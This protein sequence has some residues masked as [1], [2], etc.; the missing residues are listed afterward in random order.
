MKVRK[1]VV[2]AAGLG[3]RFLPLTKAAPKE[4]LPLLN[5]PV[6]Q[7]VL[8][9]AVQSG[10]QDIVLVTG[11]GKGAVEDYFDISPAL[12]SAL[13]RTGKDDLLRV[14]REVSRMA[15]IISVRQKEPRGLGHAVLTAEEAVGKD[16]FAVLLP[17]DVFRCKK[18]C[19]AQLMDSFQQY[20]RTVVALQEVPASQVHRYGIIDGE[21]IGDDIYRI[22]RLVEKPAQEDAPS[23]L[24]VIGRYI[25]LPE[26]FQTLAAL[27]PGAGGEIQLTDAL[28]RIAGESEVYGLIIE[29]IRYDTGNVMGFL[30]ANI[31]YAL[32]DE[33]LGPL[34]HDY[35]AEIQRRLLRS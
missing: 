6:I 7:Y 24:A 23:N 31:E 14:V 9:E 19:L 33:E 10:V 22:E 25:L 34:M 1:A 2:P 8:E 27:E 32:K 12:E 16:P 17:D 35:L 29:G 3:T 26:T 11:M 5:R 13:E 28:D 30:T 20:G 4:L 18:P 15:D 21:K